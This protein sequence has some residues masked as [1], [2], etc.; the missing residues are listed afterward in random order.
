[1]K[2][3]MEKKEKKKRSNGLGLQE[4]WKKKIEKKER[5]K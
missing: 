3:E 1:M 4:E 5:E 2:A